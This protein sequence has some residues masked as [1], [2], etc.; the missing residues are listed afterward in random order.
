MEAPAAALLSSALLQVSPMAVVMAMV[1]G[2]EQGTVAVRRIEDQPGA[3][4]KGRAGTL[5]AALGSFVQLGSARVAS[6]V[7]AVE[8]FGA[9]GALLS[10]S[11]RAT[12]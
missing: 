9:E 5:L 12:P 6:V 8:L 10:Y 11:A 2:I 1:T 3:A 7:G 4:Q